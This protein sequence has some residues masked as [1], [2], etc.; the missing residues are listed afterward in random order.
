MHLSKSK[1]TKGRQCPK[2]LWMQKNMP[3]QFDD[4]VLNYSYLDLGNAV[5]DLAMGYFGPYVEVDF[6]LEDPDRFNKALAQTQELLAQKRPIICEATFGNDGHYCMV[7]ILRR[8]EDGSFDLVEVKSSTQMKPVYL[9]DMAYQCWVVQQCGYEVKSVSLMHVNK[10]YVRSGPLELEK[11][12]TVEDHTEEVFGMVPAVSNHVLKIQ[13]IAESISEPVVSIGQHCYKPYECEFRGWCFRELPEHNAF[14]LYRISKQKATELVEAGL[15][16]FSDLLNDVEAF[17]SLTEKQQLQVLA[18]V[19]DLPAQVKK[20][21]VQEFLDGLWYP[22]YFLDFETFQEAVPSFDGQR[23]FE[24]VASQYSLHWIDE[25]GG[26]LHH[27]EYL[28]EAG[29]DPRRGVAGRLCDDIPANACVL[30]WNMGFEKGR[31]EEMA[32]LY[33]DLSSSLLTISSNIRDLIIPF[34]RGQYYSK[35]MRGSSSIKYVLPALFPNDP[36]LDYHT[37]DGVHNGTEAAATFQSLST[38]SPEDQVIKR[39]QL[40]RYCEL[41]TLAMVRIWERLCEAVES[42]RA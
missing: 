25:Q 10:D 21:A 24:Q 6:D 12:F 41:D 1:Y 33:P 2:I 35:E 4:S 30:A 19:N 26:K 38:L 5:G 14:E 36:S 42:D 9:D 40:L 34:I 13:E 29:T 18:Q 8:R 17:E 23:P 22:L 32:N 37:L 3:E 27:K 16:G 39:E 7:D 11:L 28:A 15:A 31:I 20:D